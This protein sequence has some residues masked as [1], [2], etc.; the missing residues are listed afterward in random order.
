RQQKGQPATREGQQKRMRE[1]RKLEAPLSAHPRRRLPQGTRRN[2]APALPFGHRLSGPKRG[3][4]PQISAFL[5]TAALGHAR[6]H[7]ERASGGDSDRTRKN[8]ALV[9]IDQPELHILT[10][11]YVVSNLQKVPSTLKQIHTSM[12]VNAAADPRPKRAQS[13]HLELS[14]FEQLPRHYSN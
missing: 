3:Q 5:E 2:A 6:A 8:V 7:F 9:K 1:R 10:K 13:D 14:P 4:R 12:N 11:R